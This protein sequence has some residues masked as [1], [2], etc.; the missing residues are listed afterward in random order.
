M[1]IIYNPAYNLAFYQKLESFKY[2]Q[3]RLILR[4]RLLWNGIRVKYINFQNIY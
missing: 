2:N 4:G 1:P 3:G